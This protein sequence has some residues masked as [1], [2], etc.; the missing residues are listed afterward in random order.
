MGEGGGAVGYSSE[1]FT[2]VRDQLIARL[3]ELID[4]NGNGFLTAEELSAVMKNA[5]VFTKAVNPK[6][7]GQIS[8]LE[9]HAWTKVN[10][11]AKLPGK[12]LQASLHRQLWP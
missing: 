9:F 11:V 12:S 4:A 8:N 2:D 10:V 7:E 6:R 3:F 1:M 5:N